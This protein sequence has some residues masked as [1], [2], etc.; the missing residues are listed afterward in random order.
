MLIWLLLLVILA[1]AATG[2]YY[3]GAARAAMTFIG[4]VLATVLAQPLSGLVVPLLK[5]GGVTQPVPQQ[6]FAPIIAF[7][8][9]LVV[10]KIISHNLNY[11]I[12]Y[13]F[14]YK[15]TE[16][17]K[18]R[19]EIFQPRAGLCLGL[20]NGAIYFLVLLV[21]IYVFGYVAVQVS[22]EGDPTSLKLLSQARQELHSTKF[23]KVVASRDP[24]SKSFYEAADVVS[25]IFQNPRLEARLSRYPG[26]LAISERPEFVEL[27][28]DV[29]F[30]NLWQGGAK[31][32]ELLKYPKIQAITTN[33]ATVADI[34]NVVMPDLQD[35]HAFLL[36]G[37]SAKYDDERILGRW[38]V[39]V[40][41]VM[42]MEKQEKRIVQPAELVRLRNRT[43]AL[44]G[45]TLV[46]TTENKVILKR[47]EKAPNAENQPRI[48]AE[49]TWSKQGSAYTLSFDNKPSE[50]L[51]DGDRLIFPK[52]GVT[53]VF[54]REM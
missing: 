47:G 10:A 34:R 25:L 26:L 27:G 31:V 17:E 43:A 52:D 42:E 35:L 41:E 45:A 38:S 6:T 22:S 15:A 3:Q 48:M 54:D 12:S 18:Q 33:D 28:N 50:V 8:V 7:L 44:N 24:A 13:Y 29:E 14:E 5:L 40:A 39:N 46:A 37:K 11:K 30:H 36:T 4:L 21:P 20:F 32:G 9:V 53:L 2:G 49:G 1:I 51:L 19:W 23:D 16:G